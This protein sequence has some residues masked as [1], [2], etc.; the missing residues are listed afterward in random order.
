MERLQKHFGKLKKASIILLF[1]TGINAIIAG[2]LFMIDPTGSKMGMSTTYL[3]NAPFANFLIPGITLFVVNGLMNVLTAI[4]TLKNFKR[5]PSLILLQGLLLSGWI[6]IQ[7]IWV[8]D[9]N[10]LHFTMLFIGLVLMVM[11][12]LLKQAHLK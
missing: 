10:G 2:T 7:V 8:R 1:F 3:S 11:G 9:F 12:M 4:L 6:I 5:F